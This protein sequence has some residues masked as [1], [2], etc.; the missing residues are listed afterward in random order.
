MYF[1]KQNKKLI[2]NLKFSLKSLFY[3]KQ[4]KMLRNFYLLL[5]FNTQKL[6]F[7]FIAPINI[8]S[9]EE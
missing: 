1:R 2:C 9:I 8:K 7:L 5:I 4:K 6:M 3:N